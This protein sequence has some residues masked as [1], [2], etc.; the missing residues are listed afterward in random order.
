M[1]I[2]ERRG[3][4]SQRD[5]ALRLAQD[6]NDNMIAIADFRKLVGIDTSHSLDQPTDRSRK[7]ECPMS[8][9]LLSL[10]GR[11]SV[12]QAPEDHEGCPE[13]DVCGCFMGMLRGAY[14]EIMRLRARVAHLEE[15]NAAWKKLAEANGSA[16]GMRYD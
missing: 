6:V 11:Q 4:E 12:Y 16:V 9:A 10:I 8:E 1:T 7:A 2:F 5:Y 3:G 13:A 15:Q 14:L